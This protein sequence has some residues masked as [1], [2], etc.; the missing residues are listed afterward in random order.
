MFSF[1]M[2]DDPQSQLIAS[3]AILLAVILF[4]RLSSATRVALMIAAGGTGL[5]AVVATCANS[6]MA[7]VFG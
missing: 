2:P 6:A 1:L 5:M 3:A 4:S 7:R